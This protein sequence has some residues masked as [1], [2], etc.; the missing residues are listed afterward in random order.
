MNTTG[1][2]T[3][4][5]DKAAF[6]SCYQK[7]VPVDRFDAAALRIHAELLNKLADQIDAINV[8]LTTPIGKEHDDIP[9]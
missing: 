3:V 6:E 9:F 8:A 2:I 7:E 4:R 1:I 5:C